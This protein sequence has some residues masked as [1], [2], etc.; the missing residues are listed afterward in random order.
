MK[1]APRLA[2]FLSASA[3]GGNDPPLPGVTKEGRL[4]GTPLLVFIPLSVLTP[5]AYGQAKPGVND[6][7]EVQ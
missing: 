6:G 4:K 2:I 1:R 5:P 3:G 7:R